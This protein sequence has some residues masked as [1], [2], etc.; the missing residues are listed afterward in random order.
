MMRNNQNGL[1]MRGCVLAVRGALAALVMVPSAYAAEPANDE[2]R[3]LTRP[4]SKVELGVGYVNHASAKFGEYNGLDDKGAYGIAGFDLRGGASYDSDS[5]F[6][7]S[8]EGRN[9]GLNTRS[10]DAEV[11]N[12]GQFRVNYSYDELQR[13]YSDDYRTFYQGTGSTTLTLPASF[14]ATPA[15][16]RLSAATTTRNGALANWANLQ[17]PYAT[18]ACAATGGVPTPACQGPGYLIPAAMHDFDVGTQRKKHNLGASILFA[19]GWELTASAQRENKDGTKLTGVAFGGPARGVLV[20]EVINSSTDQFRVGVGYVGEQFFMNA[21]YYASFYRN[22]TDL[23]TVESPFQG[24][25]LAPS[26]NNTARLAG[27]PDNQMHRLSLS[28]G[29]NFSKATRLTVSGNYARMTQNESFVT[30]FPTT[31]TIPAS[32]ANAKVIDTSANSTLVNRSVKDLTLMAVYKYE[33]RDSRT[34]V[35]DFKVSGGDAASAPSLFVNE[36]LNRRTQK[37][38][39]DADYALARRQSLRL[40]YDNEQIRRTADDPV[41]PFRA[42]TTREH[43]L[44]VDYRNNVASSVTGRVGY[45]RAERTHSDY[46]DNILLPTVTVAPLPAADPLLPGFQQFFLAD[47]SRDQLRTALNFEASDALSFQTGIDYNRDKYNNFEYGHKKAESWVFKLDGAFAASETL[48]Y[49]GF[50][51]YENRETQLDSLSIGRGTS[52]TII[53]PP[54]NPAGSASS[55]VGY[56]A[57]SGHLPADEGTDPC[58]KWTEKQRDKVHTFGFGAKATNL[59]GGKLELNADLAY[60]RGRTPIDVTGG[61]YFSNGNTATAPTAALPYNNIWIQAQAFPDITSNMI[62]LRLSGVYKLGKSSALRL[63]YL[64]R[65]L[66]SSDWQYDAYANSALGVLAIPVYPGNNMMSPNYSVQAVGVSYLY[67]FR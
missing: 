61:S 62:D 33:N 66:R 8:A 22:A 11:G 42:E 4:A 58:R 14:A 48:V 28:G 54:V 29:Y 6:R 10:V 26:F 44:R 34:P 31:W 59:M 23:W 1:L 7:W 64:L 35:Y 50:Y 39:L 60:S 16:A 20:P 40:G 52:V 46:E 32:S 45:S 67:A 56:F 17:S 13:N 63:N 21:N 9:L 19:P 3:A 2:V 65:R 51:T 55:C 15:A 36:P 18:A 25:L 37:L 57:A 43:T 30:G 24:S 38:S 12:Q 47:R 5:A 41:S 49:N 53:D 27:A